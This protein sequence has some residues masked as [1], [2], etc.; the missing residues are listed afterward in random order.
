MFLALKQVLHLPKQ[1]LKQ[2]WIHIHYTEMAQCQDQCQDSYGREKIQL[3]LR[4]NWHLDVWG[5]ANC[6]DPAQLT[7]YS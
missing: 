5:I 3:Q 6:S 1:A 4:G 2:N 7:A